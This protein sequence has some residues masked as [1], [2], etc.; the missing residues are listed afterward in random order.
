[1]LFASLIALN[2]ALQKDFG[3][4][5]FNEVSSVKKKEDSEDSPQLDILLPVNTMT[6]KE[7]ARISFLSD[8]LGELGNNR[9]E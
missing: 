1:M 4:A 7:I 8:A 6:W 2:P 9:Q 3:A 5:F